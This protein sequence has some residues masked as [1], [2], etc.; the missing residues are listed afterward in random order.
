MSRAASRREALLALLD[1]QTRREVLALLAYA[2]DDAGGLMNPRYTRVRADVS[3]DEA[4]SYLRRQTRERV[5]QV[6]RILGLGA[7]PVRMDSQAKYGVVARGEASIYLRLPTRADYVEKIWD[8]AA[9][10]RIVTEAGGIVTDVRG[11]PLDFG[12]GR[13]L[14]ANKGVIV[15]NGSLHDQVLAAVRTVLKLT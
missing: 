3:V 11:V 8:H 9:G 6:A 7:P 5:A 15:T 13:G 4:I 2:E 1:E 14:S 12:L 10:A